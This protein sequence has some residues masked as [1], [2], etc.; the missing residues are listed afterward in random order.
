VVP[1]SVVHIVVVVVVG[2]TWDWSDCGNA[3]GKVV[4]GVQWVW[5]LVEY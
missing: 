4:G 3:E 2:V 5:S 1:E